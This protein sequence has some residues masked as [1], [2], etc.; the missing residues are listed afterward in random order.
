MKKQLANKAIAVAT[1]TAMSAGLVACS[2]GANNAGD[3]TSTA[4]GD[5]TQAT[6]TANNDATEAPAEDEGP[7]II[8]D[9]NGNP[10][11]LGGCNVIIIV[12]I[13]CRC[14]IFILF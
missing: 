6:D 8:T 5:S 4:G 14:P 3:G 1:I 9:E 2:D 7:Q 13:I 10:I 11:D 12:A